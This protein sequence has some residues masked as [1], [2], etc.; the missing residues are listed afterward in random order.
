MHFKNKIYYLENIITFYE[1]KF[2]EN[3]IY[4]KEFT[5]FWDD[6]VFIWTILSSNI[7]LILFSHSFTLIF[8]Y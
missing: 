6:K 2:I 1:K 7:P 3:L 8:D 5:H 4:T